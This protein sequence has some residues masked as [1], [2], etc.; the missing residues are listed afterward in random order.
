MIQKWS[1][2][3]I[4]QKFFDKPRKSFLIRELS[5]ETKIAATSVRQHLK[6]LIAEG[7]IKKENG[8]LYPSFK[9]A[10]ENSLFKL[11]KTQN[12]ILRLHQTG[13]LTSLEKTLYPSCI[14][15]FGSVS[16]GED[17]ESS[18]IDLFIQAKQI[19]MDLAK[20]EKSLN[21]KI[22]ILF[23]PEMKNLSEELRNNLVN[24]VIVYGYLK[25]I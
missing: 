15:L 9:A 16:H 25:L 11:L 6:I 17:N 14:V 20:F 23:E 3:W 5:R 13:L 2:Y 22:N 7:L 4:L 18:D 12:L 19:K 8:G 10:Q 24:G 21:R 1:R